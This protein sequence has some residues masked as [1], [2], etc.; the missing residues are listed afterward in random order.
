MSYT[1]S[2]FLTNIKELR[3]VIGS[4][5]LSI[6][7]KMKIKNRQRQYVKTLLLGSKP[8]PNDESSEYGYALEKIVEHLGEREFVS[9]FENLRFSQF[10]TLPLDWI[11]KS[12]SPVKL[13]PNKD[14]PYIGH[15]TVAEMKKLLNKWNDE[16]FDKFDP[17]IQRMIEGMLTIFQTAVEQKKDLITF[18]Y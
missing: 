17:E 12:G 16:M 6:L 13:P 8:G 11:L 14:A 5:D 3:K 4:N 15:R 1:V 2:F 10:D 18:Y 7:E 9:E